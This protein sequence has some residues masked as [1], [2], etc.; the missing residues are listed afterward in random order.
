MIKQIALIFIPIP[1]EMNSIP[2]EQHIFRPACCR[3]FASH[4]AIHVIERDA[5]LDSI[6]NNELTHMSDP[7]IWFGPFSE[8]ILRSY[9]Y[10]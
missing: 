9:Q 6:L 3:V 8:Y 5:V 1:G 4:C 10:K 2:A 7:R